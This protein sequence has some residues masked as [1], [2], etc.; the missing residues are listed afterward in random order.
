MVIVEFKMQMVKVIPT[1]LFAL[2]L[3][4]SGGLFAQSGAQEEPSDVSALLDSSA[5]A[6]SDLESFHFLIT[7]PVGK[8]LLLG[9]AELTQVDGDVVRPFAFHATADITFGFATLAVEAIG[10][11]DEIWISNPLEGGAFMPVSD[12]LGQEL[13]PLTFFNPDQLILQAIGMIQDPSISGRESL[14]G[15]ETTVVKGFFDP[16]AITFNGTPV[17]QEITDNLTP[18]EV[19]LWIDDLNRVIQADFSGALLP[20][21]QGGGRIV[22]RVELSEFDQVL[23]IEPPASTA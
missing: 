10:I 8:T 9:E 2:V 5:A 20:S 12:A 6:M 18:L 7:T 13:P 23:P 1:V 3:G 21:E 16:A 11:D 22:R 19:T 15:M 4:L 14:N 17:V